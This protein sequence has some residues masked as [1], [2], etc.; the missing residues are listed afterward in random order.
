M[1][2]KIGG[3]LDGVLFPVIPL[4]GVSVVVMWLKCLKVMLTAAGFMPQIKMEDVLKWLVV[5]IEKYFTA[6]KIH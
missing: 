1:S 5:L 3:P 6:L 4:V 2:F